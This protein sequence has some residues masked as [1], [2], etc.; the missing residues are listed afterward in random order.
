MPAAEVPSLEAAQEAA[1]LANIHE[2]ITA[3]PQGYDTVRELPH[4]LVPAACS[5]LLDGDC[6]PA[7]LS[8]A[9]ML[10]VQKPCTSADF[11]CP[12]A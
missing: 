10:L 5:A 1:R 12:C 3:M 8:T 2:T 7:C 6:V 9:T 11:C 4:C